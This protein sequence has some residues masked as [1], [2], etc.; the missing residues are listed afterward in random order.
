[1]LFSIAFCFILKSYG[2]K[3]N[4]LLYLIQKKLSNTEDS[5]VQVPMLGA[6]NEPWM[7]KTWFPAPGNV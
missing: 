7:D 2:I 1:M 5:Y 6:V 3:Y 4:E